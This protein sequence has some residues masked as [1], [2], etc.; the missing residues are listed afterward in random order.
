[1][2]V[3]QTAVENLRSH[4]AERHLGT[5]ICQHC[6]NVIDTLPTNGVKMLYGDCGTVE[7]AVARE[8][9]AQRQ[10]GCR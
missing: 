3:E 7:C 10:S 1:M 9:A 4:G 5:V 8:G 6:G 2:Q